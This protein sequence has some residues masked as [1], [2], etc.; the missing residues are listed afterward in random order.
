MHQISNCS[1]WLR[2]LGERE[3]VA[4]SLI[5]VT[6]KCILNILNRAGTSLNTSYSSKPTTDEEDYILKKNLLKCQADLARSEEEN[7]T[8]HKQLDALNKQ[9]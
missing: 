4:L 6:Y 9:V 2:Q 7:T 8:L 5:N 1:Q 3:L